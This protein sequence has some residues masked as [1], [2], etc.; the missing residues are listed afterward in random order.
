[1]ALGYD[2]SMHFSYDYAYISIPRGCHSVL[3]SGFDVLTNFT[4][5]LHIWCI[6]LEHFARMEFKLFEGRKFK[7]RNH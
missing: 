4:K 7:E 2:G 6:C 3:V 5:E 1:M